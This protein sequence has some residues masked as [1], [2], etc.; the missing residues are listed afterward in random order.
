MD[1]EPTKRP[2]EG[3]AARPE[4][5]PIDPDAVAR[6]ERL[7][8][9]GGASPRPLLARPAARSPLVT[10]AGA[11]LVVV[12]L[13]VGVVAVAAVRPSDGLDLLGVRLSGPAAAGAFLG[14][15]AVEATVG[16]LVLARRP[17]GRPLG[18]A[19]GLLGLV[20]GLSQL[21]SSGVNGIPTVGLAVFILYALGIGGAEF[22]RR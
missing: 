14:V 5:R 22:R 1:R 8:A 11:V 7:P 10:T 4:D 20:V 21:P 16:A 13:F 17:L 15:A 2:A 18:F 9:P 12:G 6:L 3:A 19:V